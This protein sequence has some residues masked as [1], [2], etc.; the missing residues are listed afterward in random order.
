VTSVLARTG[1][2]T[3]SRSVGVLATLLVGVGLLGFALSVDF[4]RAAHGFKGDEATYYSLTHSLARD[5]DFAF[6]RVDLVRV[7]D[8]CIDIRFV[9]QPTLPYAFLQEPTVRIKGILCL[10]PVL[11]N[12]AV[13]VVI[14]DKPPNLS[15]GK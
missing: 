2:A 13:V 10:Y 15:A 5:F 9:L 11:Q 4:P 6:T 3:A 1:S 7:W 14:V 8:E 12:R